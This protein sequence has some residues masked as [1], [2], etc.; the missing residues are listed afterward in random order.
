MDF[1][2]ILAMALKIC[3]EHADDPFLLYC[4]LCDLVGNDFA[5]SPQMEEF[6]KFNKTYRLVSEMKKNPEPK[7][8]GLLLEKCKEQ[9]DVPVKQCL[10]WIHSLFVYFYRASNVPEEQTEQV[11]KSIEQDF[12]EPEQEGLVLP[13]P[14]KARKKTPRKSHN[15]VNTIVPTPSISAATTIQSVSVG[16]AQPSLKI[17]HASIPYI[18]DKAWVYVAEGSPM[19][20]VSADCPHIRPALNLTMYRATYER[21]KYKDFV[22]INNLQKNTST[23]YYLSR[24]HC[25]P[26]CPKCGEFTPIL[27]YRNPKREYKQ[28]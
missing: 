7:M 5:L 25:P 1:R 28:L 13:K 6:H 16:S 18:P 27:S 3:G 11:L 20:H 21:A 12:F 26:I 4:T 23:Y 9:E 14:K 15:N 10:R 2:T 8:I 17:V 19:V 24:N 22:R